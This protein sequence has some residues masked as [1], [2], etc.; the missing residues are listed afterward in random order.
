MD[1]IL[2]M[3]FWSLGILVGSLG[4]VQILIQLFFGIPYTIKLTKL[5]ILTNRKI[6]IIKCT[7][8]ILFWFI[9]ISMITFLIYKYT[10]Q[11]STA[12][13]I[14]L[15]IPLLLGYRKI[16]INKDNLSN[17]I[18]TNNQFINIEALEKSE[19]VNRVIRY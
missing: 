18:T 13:L 17:Y 19:Y 1:F 4:L 8:N 16:G 15:G 9:I 5:G 3:V 6:V 10:L 14:G 2:W 11:F 7:L 12:Y